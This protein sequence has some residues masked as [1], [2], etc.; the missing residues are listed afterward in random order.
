MIS[1]ENLHHQDFAALAGQPFKLKAGGRE[2]D[3]ILQQAVLLGHKRQGAAREPFSLTFRGLKG[4]RLPQG[5]YLLA[6]ESLGEME[7]FL[8]QTA[9]TASGSEFE[10]VFT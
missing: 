4:W 10:A 1:L 6:H 7:L 5:I 9:D 2:V 3:L 8:T